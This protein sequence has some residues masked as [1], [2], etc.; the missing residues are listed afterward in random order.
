MKKHFIIKATAF[1]LIV[2]V[3]LT[4]ASSIFQSKW[5]DG[6]SE[7]YVI[8]GMYDLE[9]DSIE[10][11]MLG[12]SQLVNGIS[13]MHLLN[14]YGISAYS[15]ATGSQPMLCSYFYMKEIM[16]TQKIKTLVLE[17]S[18]LYEA[19]EEA[20]FRK[21][22]DTAPMSRNK[23]DLIVE[24]SKGRSWED[25]W[26]YL[27]P[28]MQYHS[29]WNELSEADFDYKDKNSHIYRGNFNAISVVPVT[30]EE[31]CVDYEPDADAAAMD[32]NNEKY[33]RQLIEYCQ[34]QNVEIVLVKTPKVTWTRARM[35]GVQALADEYGIAY[36][37]FNREAVLEELNLDLNQDFMD[38]DHLNVRGSKK[39][40]DYMGE[41]LTG[42]FEYEDARKAENYDEAMMEE[43]LHDYNRRRLLSSTSVEDM[44]KCLEYEPFEAVEWVEGTES[45]TMSD[46]TVLDASQYEFESAGRHY[47][48]YDNLKKTVLC[49]MTVLYDENADAW[50]LQ[51]VRT[52]TLE[53]E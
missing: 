47:V 14:D 1:F 18:M 5:I 17:A 52:Q 23:W 8:E 36:I 30:Y 29:R 49:Q 48:V 37:D 44:E 40:S 21:T 2:V 39:F 11:F 42:R 22:I 33:A 24:H 26:S 10:V 31:L 4:C 41:Y 9:E 13:C 20:R 6:I 45:L 12:S 28:L 46:G 50:I 32:A 25:F 34:E 53:K 51:F 38:E 15:C 27:F 3:L 35:E 16:K 19:E 7:T 43:Y